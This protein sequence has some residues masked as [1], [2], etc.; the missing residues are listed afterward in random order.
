VA[1]N[2]K[3][4]YERYQDSSTTPFLDMFIG[5][6]SMVSVTGGSLAVLLAIGYLAQDSH[7]SRAW[8]FVV[9]A[10]VLIVANV[11]LRSIRSRLR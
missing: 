5:I 3:D 6:V 8:P 2:P 4:P 9:V 10:A 11:G 1:Q 7:R